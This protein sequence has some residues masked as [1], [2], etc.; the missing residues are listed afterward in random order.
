M[1]KVG[2]ATT[3]AATENLQKDKLDLQSK[4]DLLEAEL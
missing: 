3:K 4:V 1:A 2:E